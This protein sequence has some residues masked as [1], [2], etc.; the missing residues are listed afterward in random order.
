MGVGG[1]GWIVNTSVSVVNS[2]VSVDF[3][4]WTTMPRLYKM[5]TLE[6]V[7]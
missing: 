7:G 5:L 2:I 3:L 1:N 4:V 6:E